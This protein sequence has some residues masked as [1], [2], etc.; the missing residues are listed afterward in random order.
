MK[1]LI[2]FALFTFL[3]TGCEKKDEVEVIPNY[4]EIYLPSYKL[5]SAPQLVKGNTEDLYEKIDSAVG[6]SKPPGTVW[7]D[8]LLLVNENGGVDKVQVLQ[9]P[10][11]KYANIVANEVKDWEFEPGKKDGKAVKSEYQ[12][13]FANNIKTAGGVKINV[14]DYFVVVDSMPEPIGGIG[15]IEKKIKYPES[16]KR[17]GVEGRVYVKAFIN[18]DG[19]VDATQILKGVGASLDEAASN[20]VKETK[21]KPGKQNGKPVKVQV[22]VPI[23]FKL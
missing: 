6:K 19:N 21:F 4:S 23:Q 18:E 2:I 15:A 8:Y 11:D 10:N 17:A 3:F 1:Y 7:L 9:G 22:V 16:A 14:N 13:S 20:A 12:W 5:D